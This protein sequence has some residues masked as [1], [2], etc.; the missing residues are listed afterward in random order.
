MGPQKTGIKHE[1]HGT[2]KF[3]Q[4]F[5]WEV[6]STTIGIVLYYIQSSQPSPVVSNASQ[7]HTFCAH[8]S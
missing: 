7:N 5:A 4:D 1:P 6:R 3:S 8:E 2:S